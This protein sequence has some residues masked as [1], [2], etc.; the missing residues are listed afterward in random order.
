MLLATHPKCLSRSTPGWFFSDWNVIEQLVKNQ[1]NRAMSAG[2]FGSCRRF[3]WQ[4][5][6]SYIFQTVPSI[7]HHRPLFCPHWSPNVSI[8][9]NHSISEENTITPRNLVATFFSGDTCKPV[10]YRFEKKG[11]K[12]W[13]L[14]IKSSHF[15][16]SYS[17]PLD[18]RL[19]GGVEQRHQVSQINSKVNLSSSEIKGVKLDGMNPANQLVW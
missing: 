2:L 19:L 7:S 10:E 9:F 1:E 14:P 8:M 3:C 12:S 6:P 13:S 17:S 11:V 4:L 15:A 5:W 16:P 18:V